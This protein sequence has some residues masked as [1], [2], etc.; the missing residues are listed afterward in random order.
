MTEEPVLV[1]D[2]DKTT[3]QLCQ[4]LLER[5][6][7]H[8][9]TA[10]SPLDGLATIRDQRVSLLLSDIYMPEIDGFELIDQAKKIQPDLPVLVMTGYGSIDNAIQALDRG[11]NGLIL[12]PISKMTELVPSVQRVITESQQKRDAARLQILRPL[13]HVSEQLL[14]ETSPQPLE[15]LILKTVCEN[16]HAS[17][18]GIFQVKDIDGSISSVNVLDCAGL[19]LDSTI[20]EKTVL[21]LAQNGPV[22]TGFNRLHTRDADLFQSLG[23]GAIIVAPVQRRHNF[24]FYALR[25][26]EKSDFTEADAELFVILAR[27][28]AVALENA[29]LYSEL[30]ENIRQLEE[31]Q[32]ALI[33]MEKM[34]AVGRLVASMAHEINNPLQA[35]R[36]CL[37]LAAQK[38]VNGE[39]RTRYLK[40]MDIEL[41]RLVNTVKQM[42]DFYRPG[43]NDREVVD[44][45]KILQQV[46]DLLNPQF[47]DHQVQVHLDG[48]G[49]DGQIY[50]VPGQIQQVLFNL[51]INAVE[52]IQTGKQDQTVI[53]RNGDIWIRV[54]RY[55]SQVH[56]FIEDS[57]PGISQEVKNQ[58]FE[59]FISTKPN[60]TG[61]GL[62]VSYGIVERHHGNLALVAPRNGNGAC[63]EIQLPAQFGRSN[64]EN[65]NC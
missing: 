18:S 43:G 65:I 32:R 10:M 57:G 58:I 24:I 54:R 61:L 30:K 44:I 48:K 5:A 22:V 31:S 33:Q 35:V 15:K 9:V 56:I 8:V 21:N 29:Y 37:H 53:S 45:Y 19:L 41:D 28:S 14:A 62:S 40:M 51:L 64:G 6:G 1:V 46:I 16:L 26:S 49:D 60:G 42:L 11:A 7:Y 2:D 59:P 13:F 36:N 25:E 20:L 50:V 34:A 4:R 23:L 12:K 17:V 63:F 52:A 27:Q 47:R 38:S 39:N 55:D 3:V